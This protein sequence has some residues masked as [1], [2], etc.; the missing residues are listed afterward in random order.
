MVSM[1]LVLLLPLLAVRPAAADTTNHQEQHA[2]DQ[3][4]IESAGDPSTWNP[5]GLPVHFR[6]KDVGAPENAFKYL[7]SDLVP[8]HP[9]AGEIIRATNHYS[10]VQ[11]VSARYGIVLNVKVYGGILHSLKLDH[12]IADMC[13][14]GR[15]EGF[16]AFEMNTIASWVDAADVTIC[17]LQCPLTKGAVNFTYG[18]QLYKKTTPVVGDISFLFTARDVY[19]GAE[20]FSLQQVFG[21]QLTSPLVTGQSNQIA[22]MM[23]V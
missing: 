4:V 7:S 22:A 5:H 13:G 18:I 12:E 19:T 16:T 11:N 10:L 2:I 3:C 9:K 23:V 8:A 17:G 20:L 21:T 1:A 6:A 15:I 14:H